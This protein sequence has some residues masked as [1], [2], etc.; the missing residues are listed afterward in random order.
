MP[1]T[2]GDRERLASF[3]MTLRSVDG[4]AGRLMA[5]V[6][7][8]PRR[9]FMPDEIADPYADHA[10]PIGCGQ[11]MPSARHA[12]RLVA[13]LKVQPE[14]RILE[15]GTGSGYVT[16]L[17]ARLGLHVTTLERYKSLIAAASD[18]LKAASLTNTTFVQEDGRSGYAEMGPF[19][20]IVVHGS[21]EAVPRVLLDQLASHG[22]L[23]A[24]VG[25]PEGE[26]RITRFQKFG[27]RF[28]EDAIFPVRLQPLESGI[29][30]FL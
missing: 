25:H 18:R 7:A 22:I 16:A 12:I 30:S 11:T 1:N 14:S 29:A 15:I 24:A 13:A 21:F 17:L 2:Q 23:I 6:E 10:V 20:R 3:L 27:S 8:I 28:E 5:A 26:Q 4:V 19:D 9:R